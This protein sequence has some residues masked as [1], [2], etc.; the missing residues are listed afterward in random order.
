M[1]RDIQAVFADVARAF[2]D[3]DPTRARVLFRRVLDGYVSGDDGYHSVDDRSGTLIRWGQ[4]PKYE[5]WGSTA[6]LEG[7]VPPERW[8]EL[9]GDG[10]D[11]TDEELVLWRR[12]QTMALLEENTDCDNYAF[13][14]IKRLHAAN[15]QMAIA[16]WLGGGYSL[17][18]I[19]TRIV[20]I[21]A[22]EDEAIAAFK[23]RG[24]VEIADYDAR[25]ANRAARKR[26][27]G[28]CLV[29]SGLET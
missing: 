5:D 7:H 1:P 4:L 23:R 22:T 19:Y 2:H 10:D 25:L 13:W 29:R 16:A 9:E 14:N 6:L 20:G 24:V 11:L 15:G 28:L 17:D 26:S 21:F 8:Q 18:G 27:P 3:G 12:L